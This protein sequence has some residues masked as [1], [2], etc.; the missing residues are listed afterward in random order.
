MR[1]N[2]AGDIIQKEVEDHLPATVR[3]QFWLSIKWY[4]RP[5]FGL[6]A[7]KVIEKAVTA[8]PEEWCVP[9]CG[10]EHFQHFE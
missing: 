1:T 6:A 4:A 8:A 9:S 3:R 10:A 5:G 2:V 7:S